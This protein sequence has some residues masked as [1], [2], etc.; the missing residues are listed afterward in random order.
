MEEDLTEEE[1]DRRKPGLFKIEYGGIGMVC[2]CPKVYYVWG[3]GDKLSCK[4]CNNDLL[5]KQHEDLRQNFIDIVTNK[6]FTKM[7]QTGFKAKDQGQMCT[8]EVVKT[9]FSYFYDK[10]KVE[11]YSCKPTGL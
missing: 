1:Y 4:G 3:R 6:G 2:I 8:Y 7:I 9:A 10:R 5:R 11:G